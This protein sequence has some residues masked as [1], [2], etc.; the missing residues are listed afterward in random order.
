MVLPDFIL[1]F[2]CIK[3]GHPLLDLLD[4]AQHIR[5]ES[6]ILPGSPENSHIKRYRPDQ[7]A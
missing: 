3:S 1:L 6:A 7:G 5:T 2:L 4:N